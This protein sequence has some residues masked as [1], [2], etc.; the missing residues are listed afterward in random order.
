MAINVGDFLL[1]EGYRLI[2]DLS[3]SNADVKVEMLRTAAAGHVTLSRGQ[4]AELSWAREPRPLTSTRGPPDLPP[5]DR[6][7]V[8]EVALQLGALFYGGGR[9]DPGTT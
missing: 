3:T 9:S 2:A 7:G 4:G 6:A 1:G 5:E 8:F